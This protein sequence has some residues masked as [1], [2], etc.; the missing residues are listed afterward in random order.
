MLES[1]QRNAVQAAFHDPRFPP[2][3]RREL[4]ELDIEVSILSRPKPL[5]YQDGTDLISKLRVHV[6]GVVVRK[7]AAGATFLPQVWQQLPDP[8]LFLSR[9]CSKAGLPSDA[10]QVM[11]L[12]VMTYQVQHFNEQN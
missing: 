4:P 9:L 7:G 3:T 6:D 2:L 11:P 5:V 10:W 8:Q 1:V 12:E